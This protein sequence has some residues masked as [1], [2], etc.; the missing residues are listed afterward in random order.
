MILGIAL[1]ICG[2]GA[3]AQVNLPIYTDQLASGF[4]DWSFSPHS[5]TNTSLVHSGS[6]SIS[7]NSTNWQA[8]SFHHA[9]FDTTP[10]TNLTLWIN[11]GAGGQVIQV[12]GL[13]GLATTASSYQIPV[14]P[15]N[16]WQLITIPLAALGVANK[17]NFDRFWLQLTPSG[18]TNTYYVD[19][20]Q[21]TAKPPPALTHISINAAQTNRLVDARWFGINTAVWDGYLDTPQTVSLL[22]EMGLQALRFPG[23][24]LSDDYHWASNT[25][26]TNA[27]TWGTS[28]ANF[29]HLATNIGAQAMITV[30]YGTG[31]PAE[32]AAW[33]RNSNLTNHY[34]F[35]YW[36][37]G[38]ENYGT[39]ETDS[40]TY[41]HDAYTYAARAQQYIQQMRAADPT[42]KIGLVVTPGETSYAN[43]YSSHPAYN[44][45]T[46]QTN[47]GWT[48]VLLTTLKTLG[49]TPDF[50]IHHRY[51]EYTGNENDATLLQGTSGWASDAADLRQQIKDYF[52]T[53]GANIELLCTE[54]NSSSG[55]QSKQSVSLVNGLYY[56]D[57][58][59]QIM[60][61]EFNSFFWWDLRNGIDN[62]GSLDPSLYGWRLYG[63]LGTIN[64]LGTA[65]TNRYPHFFTAK[66][67]QYFARSGD[68]V[69]TATSDYQFLSAYAVRR[70]NGALTL[71]VINKD[72][73]HTFTTQIAMNGFTPAPSSVV[74]SYGMPQDTAAQTGIGSPDIAQ[75]NFTITGT[76]FNCAFAPY[77]ATVLSFAP[78]APVL[79]A[80]SGSR[81]ANTFVIQLQGQPGVRYAMQTATK[82][83]AWSSISTNTL[84]AS[85]LNITNTIAA[86]TGSRF[87]RAVWQP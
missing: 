82:Q 58:L 65:L 10:Y 31:T 7:V 15:A 16:T 47:Y 39:W 73:S 33:V 62:T 61:T 36:E 52:G 50:F 66:L 40:N 25:T 21:L 14:L 83:L 57:S 68:A 78:S 76:N 85:S 20:I 5:L 67:M 86:G 43:G 77:S 72:P 60:R 18:T 59:A 13:L 45:R 35:K 74:H 8:L 30:N 64:G 75:T 4:D 63:D 71:L 49:V 28:F 37:V 81:S 22:N 79:V 38:N 54:N 44:P 84:L 29:A 41:P 56:A 19:D 27:W 11:G 9:D 32:A 69:I 2:S 1:L 26:D 42:I 6:Y 51:P 80:L 12:Q 70:T 87:W 48:A 46:G 23:G 55:N 53:N 34:G 17:P 24:S 3:K